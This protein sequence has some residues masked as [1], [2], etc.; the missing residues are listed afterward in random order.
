MVFLCCWFWSYLL[1]SQ[2]NQNLCGAL[3]NNGLHNCHPPERP[4]CALISG[5]RGT[6][7]SPSA[8]H[9]HSPQKWSWVRALRM[10]PN[11]RP[12]SFWGRPGL[13]TRSWT[14]NWAGGGWGSKFLPASHRGRNSDPPPPP[15]HFSGARGRP[16]KPSGRGVGVI[17]GARIG[18]QRH[19]TP[20]KSKPL[21]CIA[22]PSHVQCLCGISARMCA[23]G[24]VWAPGPS[25][26]GKTGGATVPST[27][28][29]RPTHTEHT[30]KH[31]CA[32]RHR[33]A[34]FTLFDPQTDGNQ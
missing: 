20:L 8:Q 7:V 28:G 19:P 6:W 34:D 30:G 13:Q 3:F 18:L 32:H 27:G 16:K 17:R 12:E 23:T 15:G 26:L 4:G 10:T 21:L 5:I 29:P 1:P 2:N 24:V 11:P 9:W 33:A 31:V 22:S 25:V 14:K